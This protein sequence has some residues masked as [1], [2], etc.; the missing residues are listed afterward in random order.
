MTKTSLDA[1]SLFRAGRQLT[2]PTGH[3][4]LLR[5]RILQIETG[6]G[7][8][9]T[10]ALAKAS[11]LKL[12]VFK[13]GVFV[14][15]SS[16]VLAAFR[17]LQ[18]DAA[19]EEH[20]VTQAAPALVALA[21]SATSSA[22]I[23]QAPHVSPEA[24]ADAHAIGALQT[25][26]AASG[27]EEN[28]SPSRLAGKASTLAA[29]SFK[30]PAMPSADDLSAELELLKRAQEA[31]TSG[32][33]VAAISLL[34]QHAKQ[35]P[36]SRLAHERRATRI[37]ALCALGDRAADGRTQARAFLAD[38][39]KSPLARRVRSACQLEPMQ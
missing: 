28:P 7:L 2:P 23:E 39:P 5:S 37:F 34:D 27:L 21:P 29:R 32:N 11:P 36:A 22:L 6:V 18:G 16:L 3:K 35:F 12:V 24:T 31:L 9:S 8:G 26:K 15:A 38:F 19:R 30:R 1:E 13:A 10:A 14:L 4:D 17:L 25:A 33:A 20:S